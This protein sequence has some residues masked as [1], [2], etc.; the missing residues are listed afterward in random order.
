MTGVKEGY[1]DF[2]QDDPDYLAAVPPGV[3]SAQAAIVEKIRSGELDISG[4]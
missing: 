4:K 3:R 2:I 1:I